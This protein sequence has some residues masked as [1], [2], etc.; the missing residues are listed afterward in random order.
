MTPPVRSVVRE[1]IV[2]GVTGAVTVA[3]WFLIIDTL[4]GTPLRTPIVLGSVFLHQA[5]PTSAVLLYT[6]VHG[7]AFAA[8]GVLASLLI[9]AAEHEPFFVFAVV[10]LFAAFEVAFFAA[11]L[12]AARWVVDELA[13][14]AIVVG[15]VLAAITMLGY[16]FRRHRRLARRVAHVWAEED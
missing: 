2:A 1:G 15:N 8:F 13:G 3:V 5:S 10:I 7:V 9:D 11:T 4:R 16:F 14:W 6:V 12:I